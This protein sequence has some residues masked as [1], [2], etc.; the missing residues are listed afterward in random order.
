[1]PAF[2]TKVQVSLSADELNRLRRWAGLP[3]GATLT[4]LADA[5]RAALAF[6][7]ESGS[8]LEDAEASRE[9]AGGAA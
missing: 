8:K 2:L 1:M 6:S 9:T 7:T 4:D 5:L 3:R